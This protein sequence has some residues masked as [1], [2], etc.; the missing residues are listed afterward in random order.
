MAAP[1]LDSLERRARATLKAGTTRVRLY[2]HPTNVGECAW[3][4][5]DSRLLISIDTFWN[6]SLSTLIHELTHYVLRLD[7]AWGELEEPM[8]LGLEDA[9]VARVKGSRARS[10]WWR[11]A[12]R[13]K[14]REGTRE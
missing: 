13:A 2:E 7:R 10:A 12:L 11:A 14:L 5:G 9:L 3:T 6:G 8:I 1:T 4:D